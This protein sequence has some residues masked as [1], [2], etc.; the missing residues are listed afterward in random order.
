MSTGQTQLSQLH[1]QCFLLSCRRYK[2]TLTHILYGLNVTVRSPPTIDLQALPVKMS[3]ATMCAFAW[4]CFPVFEVE[5]STHLGDLGDKLMTR[6][7]ST[8]YA[9]NIHQS[10]SKM[11]VKICVNVCVCICSCILCIIM[12]LIIP[13]YAV[14]SSLC[15]L[16]TCRG[17]PWSSNES[18]YGSH[19]PHHK[20][21]SSWQF[22]I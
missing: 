14:A 11:C 6:T 21:G 1:N 7:L 20:I 18:P 3:M 5:T 8:L 19:R 10:T 9:I 13:W 22:L 2:I 17:V 4:P 15:C 12:H 16:G